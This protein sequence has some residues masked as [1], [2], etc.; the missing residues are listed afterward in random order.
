MSVVVSVNTKPGAERDA[1][2]MSSANAAE[3]VPN[4]QS[5]TQ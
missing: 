3:A 5:D 2:L 4:L 1:G